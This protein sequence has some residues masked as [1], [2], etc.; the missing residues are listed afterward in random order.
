MHAYRGLSQKL[1]LPEEEGER[2]IVNL[3]RNARLDAKID[4]QARAVVMGAQYAPV[5]QDLIE[6][7]KEL[8]FRSHVISSNMDK[9][10][11][12]LAMRLKQQKGPV[13]PSA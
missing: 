10:E 1:N 3:I 5:Y 8:A 9:K 7:T 11:Q 13:V 6:K 12:E 2:W 4:S